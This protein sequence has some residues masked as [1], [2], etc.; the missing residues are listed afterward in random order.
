M[1]G[2]GGRSD[3]QR[4]DEKNADEMC[5][6]FVVATGT[7]REEPGVVVSSRRLLS[8]GSGAPPG[9]IV[10][11]A[12]AVEVDGGEMTCLSGVASGF[13]SRGAGRRVDFVVGSSDLS[14]HIAV[15]VWDVEVVVSVKDAVLTL[16]LGD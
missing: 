12:S 10:R 11:D 8:G 16:F 3:E 6:T 5:V 9:V 7:R 15:E 2:S 4:G 13:T 14:D 1:E